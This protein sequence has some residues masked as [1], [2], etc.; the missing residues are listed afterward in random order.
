LLNGIIFFENQLNFFDS[1]M[2][3]GHL[4]TFVGTSAVC[5]PDLGSSVVENVQGLTW[6]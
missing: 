6:E 5:R 1:N 3:P 4:C 2:L